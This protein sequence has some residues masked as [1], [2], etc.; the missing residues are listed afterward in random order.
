MRISESKTWCLALL[1]AAGCGGPAAAFDVQ[2]GKDRPI[3]A[4]STGQPL[5]LAPPRL[6]SAA[7]AM[8]QLAAPPFPSIGDAFRAGIKGY[9]AGNKSAAVQALSYAAEQGHAP[10][11][12]KLG[13]MYAA[14]DGVP[15]DPLKAFEHFSK[16][17]D[18]YAD[19]APDSANA[20]FI[21]NAFV[22][23]GGYYVEGIPNTYVKPNGTRARKLLSYAASYFG[24]PDAQYSLARLFMDGIGG[25]QD[26]IQ[27]AR[28]LNLAAE[29]C[30]RP[31]QAVLGHMLFN[32]DGLPRQVAR[33]LMLLQVAREGASS[34]SDAWIIQL[35]DE[36]LAAAKD[37]D[38]QA[39]LVFQRDLRCPR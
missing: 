4:Q 21:A 30:H 19:T 3:L 15:P 11:Q 23:L 8:K 18:Q 36:A 39:A 32:G 20:P 7:P 22:A 12:W 28:W 1:V 26:R 33:G 16:I 24:D 37:R 27:A 14:G 10:A 29:K 17:A 13:R 35:H 2:D 31:A 5:P 9:N 6:E 25:P 38:R 34:T